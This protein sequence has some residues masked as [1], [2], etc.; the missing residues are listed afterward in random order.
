MID[1]REL[2]SL[3]IAFNNNKQT[4]IFGD[5]IEIDSSQK[6]PL[7]SLIPSLLNKSLVYPVEVYEEHL[8]IRHKN[9]YDKFGSSIEYDLISL[10]EGLLGI[11]F[12]K[13]HVYYSPE[14]NSGKA[15]T[16]VEVVYG[17]LTILLQKNAERSEEFYFQTNI[18]DGLIITVKKG[19]KAVL[20]KGYYY[21]FINTKSTPVIFARIFRN[22][23]QANYMDFQKEQGMGYFCIRKNARCEVVKNPR[24]KIIPEI[25]K[26]KG[27]ETIGGFN[28]RMDKP[29]YWQ[30]VEE[31]NMFVD[32]LWA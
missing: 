31:V 16:I 2:C 1:L 8:N 6:I 29:L 19:E 14:D 13:S 20:P 9:D 3:P 25:R 11:E 32:M 15:S 28:L 27:E 12:I 17:T 18:E 23:G 30:L 5:E 26:M 24:Y 22:K 10:P 4:L 7:K 21:T